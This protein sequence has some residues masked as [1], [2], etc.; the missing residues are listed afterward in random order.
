MNTDSLLTP[1]EAATTLGLASHFSLDH[2]RAT[3]DLH[4]VE[5][6]TG[7]LAYPIDQI[8]ALA[9]RKNPVLGEAIVR[10]FQALRPSTLDRPR[11]AGED[12]DDYSL[13]GEL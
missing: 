13:R 4:P 12:A 7:V 1:E 10:T 6:A 5:I 11:Y 2:Y 9:A 8:L 3:G